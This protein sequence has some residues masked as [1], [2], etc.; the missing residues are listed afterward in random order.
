MSA[1][2]LNHSIEMFW[3]TWWGATVQILNWFCLRS[4]LL[5]DDR[6]I[7]SLIGGR[8][9]FA[10]LGKLP[11]F[12]WKIL[13]FFCLLTDAIF[14]TKI[15]TM[16]IIPRILNPMTLEGFNFF[17]LDNCKPEIGVGE[18]ICI[19]ILTLVLNFMIFSIS[20]LLVLW[21]YG[22]KI[23]RNWISCFAALMTDKVS[24]FL[25]LLCCNHLRA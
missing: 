16:F 19:R 23:Q 5:P 10:L 17:L 2:L 22:C 20:R 3:P 4:L 13:A 18:Y 24:Y 12:L 15:F 1:L 6:F 14:R 25:F 9:V 11:N 8:A 7:L 21:Y